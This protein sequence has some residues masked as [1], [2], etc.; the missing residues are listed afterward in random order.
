MNSNR[1]CG[2]YFRGP[3]NVRLSCSKAAGLEFALARLWLQEI[4]Y[5]LH[6]IYKIT[7]TLMILI[8]IIRRIMYDIAIK[9]SY[10]HTHTC[11]YI[12]IHIEYRIKVVLVG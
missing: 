1:T 7:I 4:N 5:N 10:S 3:K 11:I 2:R 6:H 9:N 8:I 12:Y